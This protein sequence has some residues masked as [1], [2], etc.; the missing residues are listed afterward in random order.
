[1]TIHSTLTLTHLIPQKTPNTSRVVIYLL[2]EKLTWI[3][4]CQPTQLHSL[5]TIISYS[6]S[7]LTNKT[8]WLHNLNV[9]PLV[10]SVLIPIQTIAVNVGVRVPKTVTKTISC[11]KRKLNLPVKLVVMMDTLPMELSNFQ[12]LNKC[13]MNAQVVM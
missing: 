5:R 7:I 2:M 12:T 3:T 1:M 4:L 9:M 10:I 13:I 8:I 6:Q 11:K